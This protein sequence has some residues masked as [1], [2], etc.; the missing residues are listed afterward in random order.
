MWGITLTTIN[1]QAAKRIYSGIIRND[2]TGW[3][4]YAYNR[5]VIYPIDSD[6]YIEHRKDTNSCR[7]RGT[8]YGYAGQPILTAEYSPNRTH[9][10]LVLE[11]EK[12]WIKIED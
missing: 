7:I 8:E 3:Q 5:A 2:Y 1:T 6:I 4:E 12:V 9:L 10:G 11:T